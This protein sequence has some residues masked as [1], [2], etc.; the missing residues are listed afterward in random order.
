MGGSCKPFAT[1]RGQ[2]RKTRKIVRT[3]RTVSADYYP[4]L[5]SSPNYEDL[6]K[7]VGNTYCC[8]SGLRP[9]L[10]TV[11]PGR[12]ATSSGPMSHGLVVTAPDLASYA[13]VPNRQRRV[14]DSETQVYLFHLPTT[15]RSQALDRRRHQGLQSPVWLPRWSR[16]DIATML[17][18]F[19]ARYW[20]VQRLK[21]AGGCRA[22]QGHQPDPRSGASVDAEYTRRQ[23]PE[24]NIGSKRDA[25]D[26]SGPWPPYM[27]YRL[28][29]GRRAWALE[30]TS[31]HVSQVKIL[32]VMS[33][34]C[35]VLRHRVVLWDADH[36]RRSIYSDM[37]DPGSWTIRGVYTLSK[38]PAT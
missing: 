24:T 36:G 28:S 35:Q 19:Q 2:D 37:H 21:I 15:R 38:R 32:G 29:A 33:A 27:L 3:I 13:R 12:L 18:R 10:A 9:D 8:A 30:Y 34:V 1:M 11:A 20:V 22:G 6:I 25:R 7:G 23:L 16:H 26:H 5:I 14:P 31:W 17:M 4:F